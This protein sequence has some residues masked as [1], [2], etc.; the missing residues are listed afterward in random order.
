MSIS[1]YLRTGRSVPNL[2]S[3]GCSAQ[4]T[5]EDIVEQ[6]NLLV[7]YV[8]RKSLRIDLDAFIWSVVAGATTDRSGIVELPEQVE[9][10]R[11]EVITI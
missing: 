6:R 7:R 1:F 10:E 3:T 8:R 4:E 11:H 9:E 5:L 2:A